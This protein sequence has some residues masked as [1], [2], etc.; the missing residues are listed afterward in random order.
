VSG[1]IGVPDE[2]TSVKLHIELVVGVNRSDA[3]TLSISQRISSVLTNI[4]PISHIARSG[5]FLTASLISSR[6]S[7]SRKS[8]SFCSI[9]SSS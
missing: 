7:S 5:N 3:I 9:K 1:G 6:G 2:T 8:M 4:G